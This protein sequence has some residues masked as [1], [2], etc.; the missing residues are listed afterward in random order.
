MTIKEFGQSYL[1]SQG[2]GRET[3]RGCCGVPITEQ[4]D[5]RIQVIRV[6]EYERG[7]LP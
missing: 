2:I 4:R 3:R 6:M 7:D 1:A 5:P